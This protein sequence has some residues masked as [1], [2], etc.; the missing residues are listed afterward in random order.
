MANHRRISSG[1][2]PRSVEDVQHVDKPGG[3]A[4]QPGRASPVLFLLVAEGVLGLA[5][6]LWLGWAAYAV[7]SAPPGEEATAGGFFAPLLL[8]LAAGY[9]AMSLAPGLLVLMNRQA[10][11]WPLYTAL[12]AQALLVAFS[13][14][15]VL[16]FLVTEPNRWLLAMLALLALQVATLVVLWGT[17]SS[18]LSARFSSDQPA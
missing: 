6:S 10:R 7:V 4:V 1:N 17:V 9:A 13:L 11:A 18:R 2:C 15:F 12:V 14:M 16:I 8:L 3:R 5:W